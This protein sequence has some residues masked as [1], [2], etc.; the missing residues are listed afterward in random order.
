MR[1]TEIPEPLRTR[2]FTLAEAAALGVTRRMLTDRPHFRRVFREVWVHNSVA[3]TLGLRFAAAA[4]MLPGEAVVCELTAAWLYGADV[5]RADDLDIHVAFPK[6]RRRRPRT[7][8]VVSQ[9]T[10]GAD[11]VVRVRGVRVTTPTRTAF[12]CLRLLAGVERLVVADALTHLG[13]TTVHAL[14]VYFAGQHRLRNVRV[15]EQLLD[16][17][18]PLS[19]S[20]M[21]TRLRIDLVAWGLPR[22]VAQLEVRT[23]SGTLVGRLDLAWPDVMVAV[24]YDGAAWHDGHVTRDER[25]RARLRALG[26]W[27]IVVRAEDYRSRRD[28]VAAEV[29]A[30]IRERRRA[31]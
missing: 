12:D 31:M 24:E 25:R 14:R 5:R 2:P 17:I 30:A 20:P 28:Q 21:E 26:W 22:P 9:E 23:P 27:V 13:R 4:L 18:E 6:G 10:L 29:F 1:F 3:D 19:E 11:D 15:A 7:G 8:L 16:Q